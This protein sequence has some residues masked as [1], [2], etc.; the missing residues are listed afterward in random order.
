MRAD[1]AEVEGRRGIL[2]DA[3]LTDHA[4]RT[5]DGRYGC[6]EPPGPRGHPYRERHRVAAGVEQGA[7]GQRRVEEARDAAVGR[8]ADGCLDLDDLAQVAIRDELA[9]QVGERPEPVLEGL[10]EGQPGGLR[11]GEDL[12]GLGHVDA[13]G[14]LAQH[15]LARGERGETQLA[16]RRVHR[17]DVH[18]IDVVTGEH[19]VVRARRRSGKV[20]GELV[21]ERPGTTCIAR[22]DRSQRAELRRRQRPQEVA[23]DS[24]GAENGPPC[25]VAHASTLEARCVLRRRGVPLHRETLA[26][27]R[28]RASACSTS[29]RRSASSSMP[30]ERR[31]TSTGTAASVP[32]TEAWVM[33]S[34]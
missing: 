21:C 10:D 31:T 12:F 9:H 22:A 15:S 11:R 18:S 6:P 28:Q 7:A 14:L 16:M 26:A 17:A 34:G 20:G 30:T 25:L 2:I 1:A 23:A 19:L 27:P 3:R 32:R 24:A 4:R 33:A 29:A 5:H 8:E 13:E